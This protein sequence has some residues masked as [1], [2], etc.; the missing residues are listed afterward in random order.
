MLEIANILAKS[1]SDPEDGWIKLIFFGVFALIWIIS[2]VASALAKKKSKSP[3]IP[4]PWEPSPPQPWQ[5]SPEQAEPQR[6]T[7]PLPTQQ[8]RPR[9]DQRSKTKGKAKPQ[10][11]KPVRGPGMPPPLP[12]TSVDESTVHQVLTST[13]NMDHLRGTT[14][15]APMARI[16]KLV[17]S[18]LRRAVLMAEVLGTPV[19]L[20]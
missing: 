20:R 5:P 4:H 7:M 13:C 14:G 17:G 1:R 15:P 19:S 18:D 2:G 11:R 10:S 16:Q 3:G 9:Q 12:Q 8:R 6:P